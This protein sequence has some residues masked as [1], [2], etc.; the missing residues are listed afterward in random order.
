M[1]TPK[2]DRLIRNRIDSYIG[3]LR[4]L[5]LLVYADIEAVKL[6]DPKNPNVEHMRDVAFAVHGVAKHYDEMLGITQLGMTF[7]EA[8]EGLLGADGKEIV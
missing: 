2:S 5:E 8:N 3:A 6:A 1:K 7:E 4:A